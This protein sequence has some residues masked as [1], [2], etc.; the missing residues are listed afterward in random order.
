M[1]TKH[2]FFALS[3][4]M[5]YLGSSQW[6]LAQYPSFLKDI[7]TSGETSPYE[8]VTY[9]GIVYFNQN[10]DLRGRE[11]WRTDGTTAGTYMVKDI[12]PGNEGSNPKSFVVFEG[13]LY[14]NAYTI[15]NGNEL[16]KT[17][18]TEAGTVLVKDI[19]AGPNSSNPSLLTNCNDYL[20]FEANNG[21]IGREI[22]KSNGTTAGTLLV[23]DLTPGAGSSEVKEIVYGGVFFSNFIY[24]T[25]I[26]NGNTF[27][28][29]YRMT[30]SSL[31]PSSLSTPT[32]VTGTNNAD[33]LCFF[34][35]DIFFRLGGQN[36]MKYDGTAVTTV[37]TFSPAAANTP[38]VIFNGKLYFSAKDGVLG[39]ELWSSDGTTAGTILVK[40]INTGTDSSTPRG[41]IAANT[42]LYFYAYDGTSSNNAVWKTDG[43]SA[44][45]LKV[46]NINI[47]YFNGLVAV[48][49]DVLYFQTGNV[50]EYSK[51]YKYDHVTNTTTLIKNLTPLY[52][53][54]ATFGAAFTGNTLIFNATEN[55]TGIEIWK[56]D[57]TVAGTSLVK[58]IAQ[59]SAYPEGFI[60]VGTNTFFTATQ[61]GFSYPYVSNGTTAGTQKLAT[62]LP[63][64]LAQPVFTNLNGNVIFSAQTVSLDGYELYKTDGTF[65]GTGTAL[66]KDINT[67]TS[68]VGSDPS[69]FCL[70]G[71]SVFFSANDGINGSE[72]W[73]TDGTNAGTVM[74]KDIKVGSSGSS[75]D[76]LIYF[77][78]F[79]Y[80]M[81]TDATN[82]R[83]LWRSDGTTAGTTLVK[84]INPTADP[85]AS[86]FAIFNNKI[87]FAAN[88]GTQG[89][90]LWSSDGTTAGTSLFKDI[91]LGNASSAPSNLT[92]NASILYF[93]ADNGIN[94]TELWK[95]DGTS[96][97]T[98]MVS[99]I[100]VDVPV[101]TGVGSHPQ[102]L[103]LVGNLLLFSAQKTSFGRELWRSDGTSSGTMMVKEINV[104][105]ADGISPLFTSKFPTISASIFF[106]A[107]DS[108][109]GIEL[110][111]S[112]GTSAGTNMLFDLFE[113]F[114]NDGLLPSASIHVNNNTGRMYFEATNGQSGR[115]LWSF[116]YCPNALN[117]TT[118]ISTPNQ[119]Q[120]A[121]STLSSISN[122]AGTSLNY[123]NMNV[124][125]TA[126]QSIDLLPGFQVTSQQLYPLI[127]PPSYR[128]TLF[129]ADIGGCN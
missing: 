129:R 95:S 52:L 63:D 102:N 21:A 85:N 116:L 6:I 53:I 37:K 118:N 47:N 50:S 3:I 31:N 51:L 44:G 117:I 41:L 77:N 72:L 59:G 68:F 74:V 79:V 64:V 98:V 91:N 67:T 122:I 120:Q 7:N 28:R 42:Q 27:P 9:N 13:S 22:W 101:G 84:S 8:F 96:A 94:G 18:G 108:S 92:Y 110:W 99:N 104:G 69:N 106:P 125:Y 4:I 24:F 114:E 100:N 75:P 23:W 11:L 12:C 87:F 35:T 30:Y 127:A 73:K 10:D 119:K 76:N 36:L 86:N 65:T 115:E 32:I 56:T 97:G 58:D 54:N 14:F 126:G 20:I 19:W 60:S 26:N 128:Q 121:F 17:D 40:D 57:G 43:T 39:S 33:G 25:I 38:T 61:R 48:D 70:A 113:G 66:L 109:F 45:T 123:G 71:N 93:T 89:N 112:N 55:A 81:A 88:N 46:S 124:Q 80:F 2:Y 62:I 111:Q 49:N 105:T 15:A 82:A 78:N 5:I 83:S 29:L 103:T 107:K 1:K 34:G 90:E 16:W